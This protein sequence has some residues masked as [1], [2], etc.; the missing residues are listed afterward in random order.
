MKQYFLCLAAI[1]LFSILGMK[2]LF[3]PG[4]F[5]AHDIWHQVVR[6]Y[7]YSLTV[8]DGQ[9]PPFWTDQLANRFGYPLYSFSYH[10]PWMVGLILSRMGLDIFSTIRGLFI[11]SY[12]A[13]GITMFILVNSLLK[14]R[15]SALLS[16]LLYLWLP[17]HFL[18]IFV[19]GSMGTSFIF[20]FLPLVFLGIH[21]MGEK[22][23]LGIP[24]LAISFSGIALSQ[25][26]NLAFLA[27]IILIF[28]IWKF[29]NTSSKFL[30]I[31]NIAFGITLGIFISAFYLIPATFYKQN[32]RFHTEQGIGKIYERNFINFRQLIYSKWGFSPIINNAKNEEISF[33]LGNRNNYQ[34]LS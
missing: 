15:L 19:G 18:I 25:V 34:Y 22:S 31:K 20:P 16:S 14:N 32:T 12:I 29:N 21:L 3:H 23:R 2:A 26:M 1:L 27:P 6:F 28:S 11:I 10:L 8:S 30:F 4:L 9:F 24:I 7:Y 13:S 5:T 17:Y 33:Q